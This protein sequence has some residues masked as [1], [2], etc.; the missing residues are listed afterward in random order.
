M[1]LPDP[2]SVAVPTSV[3]ASTPPLS[4]HHLFVALEQARQGWRPRPE[5]IPG[6]HFQDLLSQPHVF[7]M[8]PAEAGTS[9]VMTLGEAGALPSLPQ[10]ESL[11]P[12]APPGASERQGSSRL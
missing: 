1:P 7:C 10:R 2:C 11:L 8:W 5:V 3:S 9:K 4:V 6:Q 12:S